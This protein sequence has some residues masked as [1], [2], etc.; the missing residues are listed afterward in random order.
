M[1]DEDKRKE[2]DLNESIG[3]SPSVI[4]DKYEP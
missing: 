3:P 1:F 4:D 2:T